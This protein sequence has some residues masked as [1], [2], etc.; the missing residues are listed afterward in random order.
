MR[1]NAGGD[2]AGRKF[3]SGFQRHASCA[4]IF[5]YDF[6]DGRLR[7]DLDAGLACSCT[8]GIG[9]RSGATSTEAPGAERA[10]NLAHIVMQKNVGGAW[11]ANTEECADDAGC[12]HGGF[13]D[14]G[15]KP[16]IEKIRGTHGH[17]LNQSVTLVRGERTETLHQKM[18]LFEI[19]RVQRG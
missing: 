18:E 10:V 2:D 3:L 16:L 15:L 5:Y 8:D 9:N 1:I 13:E 7:A 19:A 11:R 14:V 6:V 4:A 12:G 17:E